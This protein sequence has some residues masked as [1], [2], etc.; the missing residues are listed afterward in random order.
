[1][2][3]IVISHIRSVRDPL[4]CSFLIQVRLRNRLKQRPTG[5]LA[6]SR[7][8]DTP[9]L[10]IL[11]TRIYYYLTCPTETRKTKNKKRQ[12][13]KKARFGMIDFVFADAS[14]KEEHRRS[15]IIIVCNAACPCKPSGVRIGEGI[16]G[17]RWGC[18][19]RRELESDI[20]NMTA[21]RAG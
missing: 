5:R 16:G 7:F 15:I 3:N 14:P 4:L 11:V 10:C 20:M 19:N 2:I 12:T 1:M 21:M 8:L 6:I 13:N 18:R 9:S 17:G